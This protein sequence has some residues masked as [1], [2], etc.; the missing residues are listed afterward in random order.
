MLNSLHIFGITGGIGYSAFKAATKNASPAIAGYYNR[1]RAFA[2]KIKEEYNS[3][4]LHKFDLSCIDQIEKH[5]YANYEGMIYAVGVPFFSKHIFEFN[6]SDL[7]R[8]I[9]LDVTSL[10]LLI[11]KLC[12]VKDSN[13]KR[14]VVVT[15][16]IPERIKSIY[17]ICKSLQCCLLHC[18]TTNLREKG[19]GISIIKAGWVDTNMYREYLTYGGKESKNVL[20]AEVVGRACIEE[21]TRED[22]FSLRKVI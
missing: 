12:F 11:K 17:H 3:V 22:V 13:L 16:V 8:Q 21:L 7:H 20:E 2:Y 5:K 9:S 6:T 19:I 4:D 14:I 15:S 10:F 1:D 18:L